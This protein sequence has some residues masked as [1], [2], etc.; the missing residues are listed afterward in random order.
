MLT[1][2]R[3]AATRIVVNAMHWR[4]TRKGIQAQQPAQWDL[5]RD[6]AGALTWDGVAL[7]DLAREF[8]TPLE[9]V[10]SRRLTRDYVDFQSAFARRYP[11]VDVGYSYK[12]NPLPAVIDVLHRAGAT[13]EVI[14]E[15]EL[16]LALRLGM[17]GERIIFNGPA[18]TRDAL[19]LALRHAVKL[20]NIDNMVE[21]ELLD[22]L[23]THAKRPQ[24]VG[25]R[26]V[27]SVGWSGQFGMSI[28]DGTALRAFR[29]LKQSRFLDPCGLHVHL[30]NG[31][32]D[33]AIYVRAAREA[34]A[35]MR[36]LRA[37][38]GVDIEHLD[39]GGGFGV[40]TVRPFD[41]FDYRCLA[42]GL[43]VMPPRP[44]DAPRIDD[45]AREI[46][47]T[48]KANAPS[49]PLPELILEPGRAL[50]SSAQLLLL[51]VLARKHENSGDETIILD[52]GKNIAM[53][54]GWEY[55][56]AFLATE[57]GER[58]LRRYSFYGPLCHTGDLLF[59]QRPFPE[60]RVGDVVAIMDA[61][62]YFIPNQMNFSNPRPAVAMIDDGQAS[63]IRE[64]ESFEDI[65]RLDRVR[66][67]REVSTERIESA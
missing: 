56:E 27:T 40:P 5:T 65:V 52:G 29:R 50:S 41:R 25:V 8:G 13:A 53:P 54:P 59:R 20:I 51:S 32:R 10:S 55:H 12:T 14:S 11:R 45:Y 16:W 66:N 62:A 26:I 15:F 63:L 6:G 30:G 18:K 33:T 24:R 19:D 21:L 37:E 23:A 7:P 43:S 39:L 46:T 47:D 28:H 61:G 58:P 36:V 31:L 49:S 3:D 60:L 57:T 64:R 44:G 48:I 35:F 4:R 38:L 1:P 9:V 34:L 2:L 42:N 17:P 67:A 22:D